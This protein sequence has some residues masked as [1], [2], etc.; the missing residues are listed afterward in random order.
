MPVYISTLPEGKDFGIDLKVFKEFAEDLLKA[1]CRKDLELSLVFTDDEHIRQLN[2][3]WRKK[4]KPTDVLSFPQD[5]PEKAFEEWL[6]TPEAQLMVA[7]RKCKNCHLLGDIVISVDT[8]KRQAKEYGVPLEEE[9]K[10]LIVHGLVH[11]LGFDHERSEWDNEKFR[12]AEKVLINL[13]R[14]G[15]TLLPC[16]EI[17]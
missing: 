3:D 4:D 8:A 10:R 17:E 13:V 5:F 12:Q 14:R 7:L 9:I 11:L 1:L 15:E 16:E 2:R 6:I